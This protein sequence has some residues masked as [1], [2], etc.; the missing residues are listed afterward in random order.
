MKSL[1]LLPLAAAAATWFAIAPAF[2]HDSWFEA[3]AAP[4][5]RPALLALGTGNR[6]PKQES[7]VGDGAL[8]KQGCQRGPV[9]AVPMRIVRDTATALQLRP[10]V[11]VAKANPQAMTCWAQL[12]EF[13]VEVAPDKVPVY[14][15]E[16]AA[17]KALREAWAEMQS[18]G[19]VWKERYTKHARIEIFDAAVD[20]ETAVPAVALP[21]GMDV[22]LEGPLVQ[23]RAGGTIAF[24]VRRDGLPLPGFP[25]ELRSD[26]AAFGIWLRTDDE[27]RAEV[28]MPFAGRWLLRGTDL[29]LSTREADQWESRFVT[30]AFDVAPAPPAP[31]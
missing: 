12:L 6:F 14:F 28:R 1:P 2:A 19:V 27:G 5:G 13:E 4:P 17:P 23:P 7:S 21:M 11:P 16:I 26:R 30:L 18:R 15:D 22:V 31:R 8:V 29:R 3:L 10:R 20:P 24:R 9:R 25:I